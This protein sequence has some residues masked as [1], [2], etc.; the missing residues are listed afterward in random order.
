MSADPDKAQD[1]EREKAEVKFKQLTAA[2]ALLSDRDK[3]EKFD[4]GEC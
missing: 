3:R 4:A 2:Y 1:A